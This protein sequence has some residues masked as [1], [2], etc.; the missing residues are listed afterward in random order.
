M[1]WQLRQYKVNAGEMDEFVAFFDEHVRSARE[2]LGFT[3]AG[4]W[5]GVDDPDDFVWAVGHEAPDGWEAVEKAYYDSDVRAAL[6]RN[7]GDFLTDVRTTLLKDA[8][9]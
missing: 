2:A 8:V 3:I 7:P 1:I 9:H 6:P 5:R 4:P